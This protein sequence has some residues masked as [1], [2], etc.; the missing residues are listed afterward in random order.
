ML[1]TRSIECT[2]IFFLFRDEGKKRKHSGR[3]VSKK[4]SKTSCTTTTS[5]SG[6]RTSSRKGKGKATAA[7]ASTETTTESSWDVNVTSKE[8]KTR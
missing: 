5:T 6:G 3:Q 2:H 1:D 8:P 7:S 4:R